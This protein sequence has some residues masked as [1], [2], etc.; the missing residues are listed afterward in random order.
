MV[1]EWARKSG[2]VRMNSGQSEDERTERTTKVV[3]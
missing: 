2:N 1:W 3:S